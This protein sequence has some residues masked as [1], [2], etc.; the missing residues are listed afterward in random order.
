[1]VFTGPRC[2]LGQAGGTVLSTCLCMH[3]EENALLE[4]GRQR[5]GEGS[6]LYCDT[7]PCL[8]CSVKIAQLGISEVVYS[9]G[10][11]MDNDS[12]A[13]LKEAGVKLRQFSPPCNRLI[14]LKGLD[15]KIPKSGH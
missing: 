6:I 10:Y 11:H 3:A 4:A 5:I 12:A 2:N 13:V 8:T 14:D 1:M 7:C 9:Q 15:I